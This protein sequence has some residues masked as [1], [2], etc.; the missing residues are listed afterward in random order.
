MQATTAAMKTM[1]KIG[2]EQ[3]QHAST[4]TFNWKRPQFDHG[5]VGSVSSIGKPVFR[6]NIVQV[7][8]PMQLH[9]Q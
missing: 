7:L 1:A 3:N 5:T 4:K 9:R 6:E 8:S 2:E